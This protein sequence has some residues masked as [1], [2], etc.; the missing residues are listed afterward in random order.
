[1]E[2]SE[3][4]RK[5]MFDEG[6]E[7][8]KSIWKFI[9]G[10]EWRKHQDKKFSELNEF[11]IKCEKSIGILLLDRA[12]IKGELRRL[13]VK[14]DKL[15]HKCKVLKR[16][17]K[18]LEKEVKEFSVLFLFLFYFLAV[19]CKFAGLLFLFLDM[20]INFQNVMLVIT[21]VK[22]YLEVVHNLILVVVVM[23]QNK[24]VI[25]MIH[26]MNTQN[27]IQDVHV[28]DLLLQM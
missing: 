12:S 2:P 8:C 4:E 13:E 9:D 18:G 28:V 23:M 16:K 14:F 11:L 24:M 19:C 3:E 1:M 6:I 17:N 20:K 15:K 21:I 27:L 26:K 7:H 25:K 5:R 22:K 10:E